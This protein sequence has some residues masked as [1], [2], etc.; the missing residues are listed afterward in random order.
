MVDIWAT[1]QSRTRTNGGAP[2][3][4]YLDPATGERTELS[5]TSL[6]NAAAKIA[7]ALRAE[8]DLAPGDVVGVDLPLHWQRSAW[9]AGAWTAGC[10]VLPL[11][12]D[13]VQDVALVVSTQ[14]RAWHWLSGTAPVVAVSMH[15]F[16]LPITE[17]LPEGVDD[18]TLLVRQQPDSYLFDP[19]TAAT[20][21]LL[22]GERAWT[23]A[24]LMAAAADLGRA[25]GLTPGGR[26]LLR[27]DASIGEGA[28]IEQWLGALALP[29]ATSASVVLVRGGVDS[30]DLTDIIAQE[31]TTASL[32]AT[33]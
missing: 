21:A 25:C 24:E 16:G 8:F 4:T 28:V 20:P 15:P 29:L 33:P 27:D 5:A 26:L 2:L 11:P 30:A 14:D 23:Q 32:P 3:I 22:D 31:R 17:D 6:A 19:P 7:N 13:A 12:A 1:L 18:A 9:C 10:T